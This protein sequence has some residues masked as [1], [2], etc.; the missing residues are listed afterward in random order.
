MTNDTIRM[1]NDKLHQTVKS[2]NSEDTR[3]QTVVD[4]FDNIMKGANSF[5]R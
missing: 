5:V 4:K 2:E 1:T 3:A